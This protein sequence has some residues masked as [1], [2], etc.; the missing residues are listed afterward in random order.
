MICWCALWICWA[1]HRIMSCRKLSTP[2]GQKKFHY[3][4]FRLDA[5][6][7]TE[8][9]QWQAAWQCTSVM[10]C[11][12]CIL[13]SQLSLIFS[14][15]LAM[16]GRSSKAFMHRISSLCSGNCLRSHNTLLCER[17]IRKAALWSYVSHVLQVLPAGGDC[18]FT[19]AV[20]I[21]Q[22]QQCS[23]LQRLRST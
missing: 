6:C 9:G 22:K 21:K 3:I 7:G 19:C 20:R 16:W 5:Q 23:P 11:L 8:S 10:L 14:A 15:L 18:P 17:A 1:C 12:S 2:T 4:M 13:N